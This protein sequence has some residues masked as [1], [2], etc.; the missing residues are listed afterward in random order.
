MRYICERAAAIEAAEGGTPQDVEWAVARDLDRSPTACSSCSTGR[1]RP[2]LA[3]ARTRRDTR[4]AATDAGA[5]E[6]A[7]DPVKYALRNVFKVPGT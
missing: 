3:A 2:G 1:R 4:G 5:G 7:F 6:A